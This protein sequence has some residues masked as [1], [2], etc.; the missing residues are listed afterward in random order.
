[1]VGGV[2]TV[3]TG[4]VL[5]VLDSVFDPEIPVLTIADLG[6]LRSVELAD[7]CIIVTI[8]PTYSGCPAMGQIEADIK[9]AVG[10]F[11]LDV[12]VVTLFTP[13]WTTDW[14]APHARQALFDYGISP[15]RGKIEPGATAVWINTPP[16]CPRCESTNT[17][18]ISE[19]AS[20]ACKSMYRC[21]DCSEPFDHF[22]EI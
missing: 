7:D 14:M 22:K 17:T 2:G 20:T 11:G 10:I 18:V 9:D 16:A 12:K 3:T 5:E 19:F 6:V 15:P 13:T 1:M 8:T 21:R 4:Q